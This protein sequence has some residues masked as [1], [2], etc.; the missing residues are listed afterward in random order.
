VVLVVVVVLLA[1]KAG[2]GNLGMSP[3][4][5]PSITPASPQIVSD[6]TGIP[7][8][9]YNEVGATSPAEVIAPPTAAVHQAPLVHDGKAVVFFYGA[10]FCGYCAGERWAL[11]AALAR[12]GTFAGLGYVRSSSTQSPAGIESFT[13]RTVAFR[14]RYVTLEAIE[15]RTDYNPTGAE[16]T[17]LEKPDAQQGRLLT[18]FHVTGYPFIDFG[19]RYVANG[20]SYSPTFLS[21]L[22]WG[23]IGSSLSA[24]DTTPRQAASQQPVAQTIV[25]LANYYTAAIC[26]STA[27]H[28]GSVCESRAVAEATHALSGA[29]R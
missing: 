13:F 10:E 14:S 28:P 8:A 1:V 25:A 29:A 20:P 18:A 19:N 21:G 16:F 5:P 6:V 12:F 3:P 4:A 9:V 24:L 27:D 7:A 2:T 23:Q 11:V 22:T 26:A 15:R 17:S